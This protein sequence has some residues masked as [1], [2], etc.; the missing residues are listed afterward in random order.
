MLVY[1]VLAVYCLF[2]Y[3]LEFSVLC[4]HTL[5]KRKTFSFDFFFQ[6]GGLLE[7]ETTDYKTYIRQYPEYIFSNLNHIIP[8]IIS[9]PILSYYY[10]LNQKCFYSVDLCQDIFKN[11][12]F[13]DIWNM[14]QIFPKIFHPI[15][16][17]YL[18]KNKFILTSIRRLCFW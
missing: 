18:G 15:C 11:F 4:V 13:L 12:R 17:L 2:N 16:T 10:K 6:C 1:K 9:V 14:I 3:F 7:K 5:E 8:N